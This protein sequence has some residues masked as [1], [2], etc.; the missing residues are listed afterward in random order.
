MRLDLIKDFKKTLELFFGLFVE[1][2]N[3]NTNASLKQVILSQGELIFDRLVYFC[4]HKKLFDLHKGIYNCDS[5]K[6][7]MVIT[8]HQRNWTIDSSITTSTL[9]TTILI[10]ELRQKYKPLKTAS[11]QV[12]SC[13]VRQGE[14][15][16][17]YTGVLVNQNK[18]NQTFYIWAISLKEQ[19]QSI[20]NIVIWNQQRL[21]NKQYYDKYVDLLDHNKL[22]LELGEYCQSLQIEYRTFQRNFK[23]YIGTSF[24][25]Y[26][27]QNRLLE[28]LYLLMFTNLSVNEIAFKC[29][30][31]NYHTF[32]KAFNKNQSYTPLQY[33]VFLE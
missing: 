11:K 10:E 26:H 3:G 8:Q 17:I 14:T 28:S 30:Y 23:K 5:T 15:C 2:L 13:L 6:T 4:C 18:D 21:L 7:F 32:L 12:V 22:N 25:D 1:K 33:R 24:Y 16:I 29:G 20:D 27:I 9:D 31:T 19:V